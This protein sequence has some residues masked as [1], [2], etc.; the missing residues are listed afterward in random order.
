MDCYK[1]AINAINPNK[2]PLLAFADQ[3]TH[4]INCD[5]FGEYGVRNLLESEKYGEQATAK[6]HIRI[7]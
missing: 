7:L 1:N 4:Q 5:K 2:N 3:S 6:T